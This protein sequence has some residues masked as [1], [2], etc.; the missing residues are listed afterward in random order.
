MQPDDPA[1]LIEALARLVAALAW[2]TAVIV[3][4]ILL[5]PSVREFLVT[6]SEVRLKGGGFEASAHRHL[7]VDVSRQ[8]LHEFWRPDGK[9]N[10]TNAARI[11]VCMRE[12]G[13]GGSVPWLINAGT[14]EDRARVISCL[15][16]QV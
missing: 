2:P 9:V 16:L 13:I 1:R 10:R 4:L 3:A 8:K 14:A 5:R 15:S 6:L 7:N 12:L 11:A